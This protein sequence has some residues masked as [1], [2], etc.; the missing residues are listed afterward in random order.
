VYTLNPKYIVS[1]L[2]LFI[3]CSLSAK[4]TKGVTQ[5]VPENFEKK[6]AAAFEAAE[7]VEKAGAYIESIKDLF[8]DGLTTLPIGI[9]KGDYCLVIEKI[10]YNENTGKNRIYASCAF[11][12]KDTGQKIAFAGGVDIEGQ[13]GLGTSGFL[14]IVAPVDRNIGEALKLT[15]NEGTKAFFGCNGIESFQAN[16]DVAF[17]SEKI[18]PVDANG[19]PTQEKLKT[20]FE[21]YF[22]DF[23]NFTASFD[24]KQSFSFSGLD[25]FIFALHGATIDQS[26]INTPTTA[27]FPENY[28]Q[29]N[30]AE[31]KNLW[32]GISVTNASVTLPSFFKAPELNDSTKTSGDKKQITLALSSTLI[33]E[34][35]F[36]GSIEAFD[37]VTSNLLDPEEWAL[38]L[39][40]FKLAILRNKLD[41]LGIGG[42]INIPPLGKNSLL[43]YRASFDHSTNR[44]ELRAEISGKFDFPVLRSTLD[45][46]KNSTIDIDIEDGKLF[47]SINACGKLS[48]KAP[49]NEDDSTKIF[50]VPGIPFENLKITRKAPYITIGSIG[51]TGD[52]SSPE[53]AGFQI[54]ISD[55]AP[56]N[57][58]SGSGLAFNTGVKISS[59]FG[60]M[61]RLKLLGDYAK[62]KFSSVEV[63]R[64]DVEY[65][66]GAFSIDGSVWMK[67]GDEIYGSGFR[68]DVEF[69]VIDKFTFDAVA[70]FGKKEDFR[71]FLTDV[72]YETN[73]AYGLILAP[74]PISFYGFGG[75]LYRRMQQTY[76]PNLYSEFGQSLSNIKYIPDKK[77][78]MGFMTAT[79]FGLAGVPAA[80][81]SK[82]GFEIQFNNDGGLNFVQLRGDASFMNDPDKWGKLA[83]N[84]NEKVKAL[85]KTDGKLK[86]TAKSDLGVPENKESGFLTA[87]MLMEY[88]VAHKTF[89]ADL[90]A[91]L[92]AGFIKGVGEND[93]MGWASLRVAPGNWHAYLGTPSDRLGVEILGLAR[94]DG[95][96]M[97]GD[98]IP[99]L[100]PPPK[101]VLNNFS[102]EKQEKLNKRNSYNLAQGSGIAFGQSL[103]I[104]IEAR[105]T[106]FYASLGVGMGA[107]FLLKKYSDSAYCLGSSPPLGINSWYARAQAWAWIAAEFGMEARIFGRKRSFS[108]LDMSAAALLQGAGPNPFYFNGTVAGHFRALGGLISGRCQVDFEI[109][110]ECLIVGGGSPFGEEIIGQLTPS[111]G[112]SEVNVFAAPQAV[113]NIPVN[114]PMEV[115]ESKGK[116]AWYRV[117]LEEFTITNKESG[118]K[119]KGIEDLSEDNRTFALDPDEPFEN[120]NNYTVFAKVGFE[121]KNNG[122]WEKVKDVNGDIVY[123]SKQIDFESGERPDYILPEHVKYSYPIDRQYNF[124]PEEYDEGY[125]L[126]TENY[127]YLFTTEKPEGFDQKVMLS[128]ASGSNQ[129]VPFSWS[130]MAKD[131]LRMEIS[132][133]TEDFNFSN[134][135]I[136]KL[137][138]VNVP[139]KRAAITDNIKTSTTNLDNNDSIQVEKQYAE[140]SLALLELKE[141][142]AMDFRT[143]SHD[144][145]DEKMTQVEGS[146]ALFWQDYP[147][148]YEI[149]ANLYD[150]TTTVEVFDDFE[151]NMADSS[152]N[153]IR[154]DPVYNSTTWYTKH[155]APMIYENDE[156]L[157]A[158]GNRGMKPPTGPGIIKISQMAGDNK[159]TE[160]MM[161]ANSRPAL[162]KYAAFNNNLP[163][164]IDKDY[165]HLRNILANKVAYSNLQSKQVEDFLDTNHIPDQTSGNYDVRLKYKLP[166]KDIVT[167]TLERTIYARK[168]IKSTDN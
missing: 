99:E 51:L 49:I 107:E 138:I 131:G 65:K 80:F 108:I 81:N 14:E 116:T 15:F 60:G 86:V 83:D 133:S 103:G 125:L 104:D 76:D 71:Y 137:A 162:S 139:Q 1:L 124:Y 55:I 164:Y 28:F 20:T 37:V 52:I 109:G 8:E 135:E 123:E 34:N 166:G 120:N 90:S 95:Y 127:R 111:D 94:T 144:T 2:S 140:G 145:F 79:K 17:T 53:I 93:R 24:F 39:T 148:V 155:I 147:H 41:G 134:N 156:L 168:H 97:I 18:F 118:A 106:P 102:A 10:S 110:D 98:N 117:S 58:D 25:G 122:K 31:I 74:T 32:K 128:N 153:I 21:T 105:L 23:D 132:F 13:K 165:H 54:E 82:V 64:I 158:S 115:D 3:F 88:D 152:M 36:S 73:P 47:P 48:I 121:K 45:L 157:A 126:L 12:F 29:S 96:F 119:L 30:D 142:V 129:T 44:I 46:N 78:G 114:T 16:I 61:T 66:S 43:G 89:N 57:D 72:F 11:K 70:V 27:K 146:S 160:D 85:E 56:F 75:G 92:N 67:N 150:N 33:D 62:W 154:I 19:N 77:T 151:R 167:T 100:P 7:A 63:E 50:K 22:D 91:Y 35:G 112:E 161:L 163:Y 84:I 6:I 141:I 101:N 113:F 40:D 38:S 42:D 149:N 68:G 143:S 9:K 5:P 136:Y 87:S 69:S 59:M 130:S 4:E 159:L 26:D